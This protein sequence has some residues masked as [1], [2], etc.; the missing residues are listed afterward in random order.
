VTISTR[1]PARYFLRSLD[2]RGAV[3]LFNTIIAPP[4]VK[5]RNEW[6]EE[7]AERLQKL[8]AEKSITLEDLKDNPAFLDAVLHATRAA[9]RSHQ[10]EKRDALRN[11]VLNSALPTSPDSATQQM[12][13]SFVDRFTEWHIRILE[14]FSDPP[15]WAA[16]HAVIFP[17]LMTGGL[18]HILLH[19]FPRAQRKG[20]IL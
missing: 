2:R 6:M 4:I 17:Q 16:K 3:E 9:L 19:A 7:I 8:A 12:F 14:L 11:A 1:W 5:L 10:Q 20:T 15:R 13:V 18:S